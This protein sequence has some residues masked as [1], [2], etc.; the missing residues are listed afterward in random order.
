MNSEPYRCRYTWTVAEGL[1]EKQISVQVGESATPDLIPLDELLDLESCLVLTDTDDRNE[2]CEMQLSF[3]PLYL[4][5]AVS[6]V[7]ECPVIECYY[8]RLNEYLRT[9]HGELVYTLGDVKVFR[10]DLR[11]ANDDI[12]ELQLKFITQTTVHK[13]LCLYGTRLYLA[14]NPNPLRTVMAAASSGRIN[15]AKVQQRLQNTD[16]SSRAESCKRLVLG[17]LASSGAQNAANNNPSPSPSAAPPEIGTKRDEVD[18]TLLNLFSRMQ[19][20]PSSE[21]TVTGSAIAM[22]EAL[23]KQYIDAKFAE[24]ERLFESKM[25]AMERRQSDK[26]DQILILLQQR[27]CPEQSSPSPVILSPE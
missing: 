7:V 22:M 2:A 23:M 6:L 27:L 11:L 19:T 15:V 16:L 20:V 5:R 9:V 1:E 13:P 17:S 18:S 26:L 24:M 21:G 12:D 14:R 8:G 3:I 25:N 10:F 4:P